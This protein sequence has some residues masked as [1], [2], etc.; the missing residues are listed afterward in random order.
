[1]SVSTSPSIARMPADR[2]EPSDPHLEAL[3]A[4]FEGFTRQRVEQMIRRALKLGHER[5]HVVEA[6]TDAQ[7]RYDRAAQSMP[8][9]FSS[10]C[11]E[12]R[13]HQLDRLESEC[14]AL[15]NRLHRLD[16]QLTGIIR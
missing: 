15:E 5:A 10:D 6:V 14:E 1:M 11:T 9:R 7:R 16:G 12:A 2:A 4:P 3:L 13:R 8:S